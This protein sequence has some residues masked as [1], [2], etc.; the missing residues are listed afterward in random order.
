MNT[1]LGID[2]RSMDERN[3][4]PSSNTSGFNLPSFTIAA[5]IELVPKSMHRIPEVLII[6]SP[7]ICLL[8]QI[9]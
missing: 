5:R 3:A 7:F 6:H 9:G 4:S 1:A 2:A 8:F